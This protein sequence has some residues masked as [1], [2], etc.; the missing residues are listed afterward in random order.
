MKTAA[1]VL[2]T[3]AT[4]ALTKQA[5]GGFFD[6]AETPAVAGPI[7]SPSYRAAHYPPGTRLAMPAPKP[8]PVPSAVPPPAPAAPRDPNMIQP[9]DQNSLVGRMS[10]GITNVFNGR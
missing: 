7:G 4:A 1:D 2:Y 9:P 8:P 3:L 5:Y 6:P 10:R